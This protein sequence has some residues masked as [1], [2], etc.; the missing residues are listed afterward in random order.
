MGF[1]KRRTILITLILFFAAIQ[2]FSLY[3]EDKAANNPLSRLVLAVTY[4]PQKFVSAS[5]NKLVSVWYEYLDLVQLKEDNMRLRAE[6]EKL[7]QERF[8]LS[9]AEVQ[10][11]RLKKLLDFK[12]RSSYPVVS[13]NVI[14]ASPSILRSQVVVIDKGTGSGVTQ[15]MPVAS[16]DGIVGRVLVSSGK[17]SEVLLITDPV[18]AVDAYIHRT[19]ARGIVKGTGSG[20]MMQYIEKKSDVSIGDKVISSGKDGFFPKGVIIGTVT[21][22]E[23]DGSF[24]T[25]TVSPHVDLNSLEEV[26][27]ILKNVDSVVLNE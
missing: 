8:E 21:D 18:S 25:A 13:A 19:R 14:G 17:S 20:C 6:I 11:K 26:V 27:I 1:L 5:T 4:Y 24:I 22:I 15:G 2:L 10:N 23:A 12:E 16:F 3:Q 9:E 7:R